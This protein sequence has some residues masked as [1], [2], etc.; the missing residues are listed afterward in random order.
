MAVK[1]RGSDI[2]LFLL[3][4]I[5]PGVAWQRR[6]CQSEPKDLSKRRCDSRSVG[7]SAFGARDGGYK[8]LPQ[9]LW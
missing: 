2:A 7:R 3:G 5:G 8:E 1:G 9:T 4:I 6:G